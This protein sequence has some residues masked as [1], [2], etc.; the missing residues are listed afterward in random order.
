MC[1]ART[2]PPSR[3][4]YCAYCISCCNC[5]CVLLSEKSQREVQQPYSCD[6]LEAERFWNVVAQQRDQK[7]VWPPQQDCSTRII[8]SKRRRG[9]GLF[10]V[11]TMCLCLVTL[12]LVADGGQLTESFTRSLCLLISFCSISKKNLLWKW[13]QTL[14]MLWW[15]SLLL[16]EQGFDAFRVGWFRV[17]GMFQ[18]IILSIRT[19]Y[20]E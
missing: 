12:S 16:F 19:T 5:A 3:S 4:I 15:V 17:I 13:H 9:W 14:L 6:P 18:V 2:N 10:L 1:C 7:M 20:K 8:R 11:V